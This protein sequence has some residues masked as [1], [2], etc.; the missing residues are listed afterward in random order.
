[1]LA[2]GTIWAVSQVAIS[3]LIPACEFHIWTKLCVPGYREAI[4]LGVKEL[5]RC[6]CVGQRAVPHFLVV[7]NMSLFPTLS[8]CVV[9]WLFGQ[10]RCVRGRQRGLPALKVGDFFLNQFSTR[11]TG[12]LSPLCVCST[13]RT[14][15]GEQMGHL[16]WWCRRVRAAEQGWTA[17]E[18]I[19]EM[20]TQ[21]F[22]EE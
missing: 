4:T 22:L 21:L 3:E 5:A 9:P 19:T 13:D 16:S 12:A 7:C 11:E 6:F 1:M 17:D 14:S 18:T 10:L 8:T 20:Q 15:K 2:P